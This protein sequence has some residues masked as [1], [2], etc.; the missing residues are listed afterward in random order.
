ML[1]TNMQCT[2]DKLKLWKMSN[3]VRYITS[4]RARTDEKRKDKHE[5]KPAEY[6]KRRY[7]DFPKNAKGNSSLLIRRVG[8]IQKL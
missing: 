5:T 1:C 3:N 7:D 8:R 4:Y 2:D 6:D